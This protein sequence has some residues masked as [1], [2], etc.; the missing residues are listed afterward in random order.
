MEL[1]IRLFASLKDRA[2][3]EQVTVTLQEPATVAA[4]L[5]A[6][7]E[8]HPELAPALDSVLVAVNRDFAFPETA[9]EQGDEVAL[10]PPVSGGSD[11]DQER[12]P[13]PVHFAL[14]AEPPDVEQITR[15][16]TTPEVG[17]VVFFRGSVRGATEREGLP[18]ETIHLE[19]EAYEAMARQK[20]AQIAREIWERWPDVRGV[21]IVQRIGRL[22]VGETTTFVAC[23]A[24]HRDQGA[25]EA[26][27]YGIDRLKE[28]VPVWKKEVGSDHSVWIE[29]AYHPDRSDRA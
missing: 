27:R 7:R 9:I 14:T 2:G 8:G 20:M 23:A 29:G 18:P 3:R 26:A 25:F 19:Y 12:S 16:L 22:A 28:I 10:F 21:A 24:G 5:E 4:L 15:R 17:A 13:H 1:Q 11:D 6:L